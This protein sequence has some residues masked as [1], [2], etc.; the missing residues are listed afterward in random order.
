M[1]IAAYISFFHRLLILLLIL[2]I[3]FIDIVVEFIYIVD[4]DYRIIFDVISDSYMTYKF[5]ATHVILYIVNSLEYSQYLIK[6]YEYLIYKILGI[7]KKLLS[8][9]SK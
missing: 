1:I 3:L 5:D 6:F 2:L 7:P 9:L 4:P 8:L